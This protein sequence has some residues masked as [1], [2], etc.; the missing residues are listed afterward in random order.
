M[1]M[2]I[3]QD[4]NK[5]LITLLSVRRGLHYPFIYSRKSQA[6]DLNHGYPDLIMHRQKNLAHA[7]GIIS[8]F[9][10]NLSRPH[11]N[12]VKYIFIYLIGIQELSIRLC[13][14]NP[15]LDTTNLVDYTDSDYVGCLDMQKSTSRYIFQQWSNLVEIKTSGVH[16]NLDD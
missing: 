9:M 4:A 3:I 11:Q 12:I 1:P 16:D 10:H 15:Q 6:S 14:T 2:S 5:L 13:M 8:I 7:I